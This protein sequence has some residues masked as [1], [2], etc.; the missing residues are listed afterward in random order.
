M[1]FLLVVFAA[2]LLTACADPERNLY[3]GIKGHSDAK[4]TPNERAISPTPSYDEY[5]KEREQRQ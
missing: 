1:R 5:K 2:L 3:E 4:R